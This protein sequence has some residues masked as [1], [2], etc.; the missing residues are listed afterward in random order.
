VRSRRPGE[1]GQK[2][3]ADVNRLPKTLEGADI[4]L[5]GSLSLAVGLPTMLVAFTRYSQDQSFSVL[6]RN[7]AFLLVM[8]AGSIAGAFIGGFLLGVVPDALLLPT[9]AAILLVSA[10]KVWRHG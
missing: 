7:R 4:K 6:G 3:S 9:L 1:R 8:A 10:V 2:R 5:A